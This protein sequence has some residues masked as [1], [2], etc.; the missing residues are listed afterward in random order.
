MPNPTARI[1]AFWVGHGEWVL[2]GVVFAL[3]LCAGYGFAAREFQETAI[4][5]QAS[6]QAD[7]DQERRYLRHVID[8]KND[9]I[10]RLQGIQGD[11]AK[12]ANE[13]AKSS[14]NAIKAI[15]ESAGTSK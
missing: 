6:Y 8:I 5:L 2:L 14:T 9:D 4:K 15:T 1:R 3:S 10:R 11:L 12:G 13:T 7:M